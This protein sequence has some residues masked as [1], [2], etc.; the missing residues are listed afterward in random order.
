VPIDEE[1]QTGETTSETATTTTESEQD[2]MNAMESPD[3]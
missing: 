2:V 3:E 1:A